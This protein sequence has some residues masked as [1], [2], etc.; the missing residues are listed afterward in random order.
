[1]SSPQS[2]G[3]SR[4]CFVGLALEEK[5]DLVMENHLDLER[6]LVGIALRHSVF[7]GRDIRSAAARER[8][9]INRRVANLLT[10]A[11]LYLDQVQHNLAKTYAAES[12]VRTEVEEFPAREYDT[13]LGYRVM[14]DLRNYVQHRD[15]PIRSITY[16]MSNDDDSELPNQ[17]CTVVALLDLRELEDDSKFKKAVLEDLGPHTK[18]RR[19]ADVMPFVREHVESIGRIHK[20]VRKL[21]APDLVDA[22]SAITEVERRARAV[23]DGSLAG[24]SVVERDPTGV[25]QSSEWI[26]TQLS[27]RRRDLESKNRFADSLARRYVSSVAR[28]GQP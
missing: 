9:L 23:A 16:S 2:E 7:P 14:E 17:R 19:W 4:P 24:L 21:I 28:R 3:P 11:R 1:M 13:H 22:D 25:V 20:Q 27:E 8:R 12:A 18:D 10:T 6:S 26:S 5:L 15:L